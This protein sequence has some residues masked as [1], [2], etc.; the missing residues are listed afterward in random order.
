MDDMIYNERV[1]MTDNNFL[2]KIC[3]SNQDY[4]MMKI[5]WC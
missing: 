1:K 5:L 2:L 3:A 4:I